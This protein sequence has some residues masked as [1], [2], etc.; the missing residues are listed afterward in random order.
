MSDAA[1]PAGRPSCCDCGRSDYACRY[2]DLDD[3]RRRCEPCGLAPPTA[4]ELA[5]CRARERERQETAPRR[6]SLSPLEL[7]DMASRLGGT[8]VAA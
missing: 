4:E 7:V 8:T 6:L 2:V 3:G 1:K 5:A